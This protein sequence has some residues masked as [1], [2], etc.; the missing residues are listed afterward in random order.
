VQP[1]GFISAAEMQLNVNRIHS[2]SGE[3]YA[4]GKEISPDL[5]HSLGQNYTRQ[6]NQDHSYSKFHADSSAGT[7]QIA[8]MAVAIA[9]AIYT[10]GAAAGALG[11]TEGTLGYAVASASIGSMASTAVTGAINGDLR[12]DSILKSGLAAGL[13]AGLTQG[14]GEA[15]SNATLQGTQQVGNTIKAAQAATDLTD[16]LIGYTVRATVTAGVNQMVYGKDAGSFGAAFVSSFVASASADAANWVGGNIK[17]QSLEN[18]AAHALVGCA[19]AVATGGNCGAGAVGGATA[20]TLNPFLDQFTSNDDKLLRDAQL[21]ALATAASGLAAHAL[22][23]DITTAAYAAQNETLN[24]YLTRSQKTQMFKELD[25]CAG[26]ACKAQVYAKYGVVSTQQDVAFA[27][28]VVIGAT[29]RAAEVGVQTV[30]GVGKLAEDIPG[31]LKAL[32]DF[33]AN[34]DAEQVKRI[35]AETVAEYKQ[36]IDRFEQ[37]YQTGGWRGAQDAGIELGALVVDGA[38]LATGVGGAARLTVKLGVSVVERAAVAANMASEQLAAAASKLG[39]VNAGAI[40]RFKSA[41]ELN[42]LMS[43]YDWAPAWKPG[44]QVAEVTLAPGTKVQMVVDEKAFRAIEK[45]DASRAFGGWATFDDVPNQ[46][47]ARNQLA[48]TPDMKP[49][50]SYVIEVEITQPVAAKVGVVGPQGT[51]LGGGNQLH[52][53]VQPA[54]RSSVFRYVPD[55]G[56]ALP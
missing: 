34:L 56:K 30:E 35:G 24:N 15:L 41:D 43:T 23:Q 5:A 37:N 33:V 49:N 42:A 46:A 22:G 11:F 27:T 17:P 13:T 19:A 51:A 2:V 31:T 6:E 36:R 7:K 50:A 32:K 44:T 55:S 10:G 3:F 52:F 29:G 54:D 26:T 1:G 16:K 48:I 4:N 18:I 40:Q 12:L 53:I 38:M 45:G 28:G 20:A 14:L 47:Y 8:T 25:G 39:Q 21:A 9:V